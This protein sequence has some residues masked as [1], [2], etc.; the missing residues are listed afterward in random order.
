MISV[1]SFHHAYLQE[2]VCAFDDSLVWCSAL[3]YRTV[4]RVG[5][6]CPRLPWRPITH[7]LGPPLATTRPS[8]SE[9]RPPL[10]PNPLPT[11]IA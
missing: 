6:P 9:P 8:L 11:T 2:H 1:N 7:L 3:L 4:I 10:L 5:H